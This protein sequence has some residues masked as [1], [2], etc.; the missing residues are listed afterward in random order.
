M[1]AVGAPFQAIDEEGVVHDAQTYV[2]PVLG[3]D[4]N[5]SEEDID[6]TRCDYECAD[7][8]TRTTEPITCLSCLGWH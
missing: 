2:H 8:W 5:I 6:V 4:N 1:R 3:R 7:G